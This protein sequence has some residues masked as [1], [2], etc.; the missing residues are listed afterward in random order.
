MPAVVKLF[1]VEA[2]TMSNNRSQVPDVQKVKSFLLALQQNICQRLEP[3]D[4]KAS[5]KADSWE[6][7]EGGGGTSRVLTQGQVFEQA[8]VNFSHVMGAAMPASATAHRPELAGRSFEAMGVSLVIHPNNPYIPTTHANVRF[9]IASKEGAD[10]VWWFGGGFDLT[11][12]YPFK[13][14]VVSW[15]QTAKDIC[16]PFGEDVYPKYKK[17]CDEYFF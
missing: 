13:E 8:G 14:D 7:E 9:F 10:P 5:F 16:D 17:W 11:P 12:Y 3:L 15:H 6:R 4:G 1:A 2:N